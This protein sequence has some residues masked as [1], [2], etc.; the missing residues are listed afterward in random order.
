MKKS[1]YKHIETTNIL[2][3]KNHKVFA[4]LKFY[5]WNLHLLYMGI[6]YEALNMPFSEHLFW[7]DRS[8]GSLN[9]PEDV[10]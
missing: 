7:N 5:I 4:K 2:I 1:Y 3:L 10:S 6:S 8:A 9:S